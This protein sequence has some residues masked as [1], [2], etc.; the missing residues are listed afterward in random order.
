VRV[1]NR[2]AV[3]GR[4]EVV[5]WYKEAFQNSRC[6]TDESQMSGRDVVIIEQGSLDVAASQKKR[7]NPDREMTAPIVT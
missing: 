3:G 2:K 7:K 5:Q 6:R 4:T 1:M